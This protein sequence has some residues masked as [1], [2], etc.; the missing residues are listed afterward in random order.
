MVTLNCLPGVFA[1][2]AIWKKLSTP[3]YDDSVAVRVF[4]DIDINAEVKWFV[5]IWIQSYS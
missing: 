4:F 1:L 2:F 3:C 5:V